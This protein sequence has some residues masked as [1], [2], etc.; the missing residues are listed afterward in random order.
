[1]VAEPPIVQDIRR[2]LDDL[3]RRVTTMERTYGQKL[4]EIEQEFATVGVTVEAKLKETQKNIENR[5]IEIM[6]E[7][8]KR[9]ADIEIRTQAVNSNMKIVYEGASESFRQVRTEV[10]ATEKKNTEFC[11]TMRPDILRMCQQNCTDGK[12]NW[13]R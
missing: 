8:Q 2:M 10:E 3:M 6:D 7:A 1:M 13:K 5:L 12:K 9:F 4:Q 11:R